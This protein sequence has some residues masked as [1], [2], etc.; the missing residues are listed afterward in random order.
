[1]VENIVQD[2]GTEGVSGTCG[3]NGVLLKEWSALYAASLVISAASVFTQGDKNQRNVIFLFNQCSTLVVVCGIK[4]EFHFVV[5]NLQNVTFGKTI[6]DLYPGI[7]KGFPQRRTKVR[8]KCDDA[9]SLFGNFDSM[10]GSFADSLMCGRKSSKVENTG[11]T[12]QVIWYFIFCKHHISTRI[13][14]E[15]EVSVSIRIGVDKCQSRMY[16]FIHNKSFCINSN[17]FH[18]SFQLVSEHVL[19]NFSDKS[20][21]L[22]KALKHSQNITWSSA[23]VRFHDRVALRAGSILCEIDKKLAKCSYVVVSITH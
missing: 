5:R 15:G 9:A 23:R 19:S 3:L 12:D 4:K 10:A 18:S 6:F 11:I 20:G 2:A 16:F 17:F 21:L 7:L 22:A 14:V 1:M 8:V 13:T